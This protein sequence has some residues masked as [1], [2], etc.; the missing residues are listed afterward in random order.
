MKYKLTDIQ[1]QLLE[2][3]KEAK[4]KATANNKLIKK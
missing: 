4:N 3:N 2:K 1:K